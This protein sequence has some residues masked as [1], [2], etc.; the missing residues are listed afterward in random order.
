MVFVFF[1]DIYVISGL[2]F[3][4]CIA[5]ENGLVVALPDNIKREVDKICLYIAIV[6]FVLIH[7]IA[8]IVV[9]LKV[10]TV[11]LSNA[12]VFENHPFKI[13]NYLQKRKVDKIV[14]EH[15]IRYKVIYATLFIFFVRS[16]IC[17]V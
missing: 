8:V 14:L 1:Q 11:I 16:P 10:S 9:L 2:V 7:I 15:A 6:V 13:N 3:L 5:V 12:V 4:F 17:W